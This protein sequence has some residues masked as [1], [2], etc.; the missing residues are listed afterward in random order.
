MSANTSKKIRA[1]DS[2]FW[3]QYVRKYP[4][5]ES[6]PYWIAA[7]LTA[8]AAILYSQAFDVITKFTKDFVLDKPYLFL[9]LFAPICFGL[10]TWLVL[11]FA[12]ASSGS[13]IPQVMA[14]L[15]LEGADSLSSIKTL[16]GIRIIV[17]KVVSSLLTL[18]GG[19]IL[20]REGPTIQIGA[21]IFR[22]FGTRFQKVWTG[23]NLH[24]WILAGASAGIA[25]AFNTPLGG[26]VFAVEELSGPHFSKFKTAIISAVIIAGVTSQLLAGPYLYFGYPLLNPYD[27]SILGWVAILSSILG[28]SGGLMVKILVKIHKLFHG[29]PL[30]KRVLFA[31]A[32]GLSL[33]L[34]TLNLGPAMIGGGTDLIKDMLFAKEGIPGWPIF[35][36][37]YV[38]LIITYVVG[39]A[40]GI[41]APS[42]SI[43]GIA[44]AQLA[45]WL[46]VSGHQNLFVLTGMTAFLSAITS[47]PFTASVLVLEMTDRHSAILPLMIAALCG[48]IAAKLVHKDSLYHVQAQVFLERLK[49]KTISDH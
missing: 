24:N 39:S 23:A 22:L 5:L 8:L 34:I 17:V 32:S 6:I 31:A 2:D 43:G 9:L 19:G 14:S 26:I 15:E 16:L 4:A 30:K 21:S 13:G 44:G 35:I 27:T 10:S 42:L 25:A 48:N 49:G 20:G 7:V 46:G 36:G 33:A 37:R 40:G 28:L 11:R 18:L 45:E 41:F 3:I 47:A 12:P 29:V 38:G 1:L